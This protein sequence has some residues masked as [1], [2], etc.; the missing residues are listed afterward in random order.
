[1][2]LPSRT[3]EVLLDQKIL[4]PLSDHTYIVKRYDASSLNGY[5]VSSITVGISKVTGG[6]PLIAYTPMGEGVSSLSL[7]IYPSLF[8]YMIET[9]SLPCSL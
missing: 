4:I 2:C 6:L 9:R 7:N 3:V 5:W 1:M 8:A